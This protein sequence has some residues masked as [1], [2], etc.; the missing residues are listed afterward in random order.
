MGEYYTSGELGY[1][2]NRMRDNKWRSAALSF[3]V[4]LYSAS[5]SFAS[6]QLRNFVD[7]HAIFLLGGG[8]AAIVGMI[9]LVAVFSRGRKSEAVEA[10]EAELERYRRSLRH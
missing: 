5:P 8:A 3:G 9:I 7:D 6:R 2:M 1:R 4:L 10:Y